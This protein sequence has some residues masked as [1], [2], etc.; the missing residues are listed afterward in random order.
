MNEFLPVLIAAAVIGTFATVFI[1]AYA[2]MK[3][4]KE[5][6]GFD[7]NMKDGEIVRR[8]LAYARPHAASFVLVGLLMLFAI[9]YDV[10]SPLMIG[11]IERLLSSEGFELSRL[12]S[13]VAVYATILVV[14]LVSSYFQAMVLQRVGQKILSKIREDLFSHIE[15]RM[16]GNVYSVSDVMELSDDFAAAG[17]DELRTMYPLPGAFRKYA[18]LLPQLLSEEC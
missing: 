11:R 9:F 10:I 15:W 7:R 1:V 6:L 14:S 4:K 5:A 8:L 17:L 3:N 13:F 18:S 2:L 16:R 12:Y